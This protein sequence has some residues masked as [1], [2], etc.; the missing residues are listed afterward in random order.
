MHGPAGRAHGTDPRGAGT[1]RFAGPREE[2]PLV[3]QRVVSP[4][5][6]PPGPRED[7]KE[8]PEQGD[9]PN[10]LGLLITSARAP[11]ARGSLR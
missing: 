10:V 8:R 9:N 4:S 2:Q 6:A 7:I 5:G 3:L 1:D 11:V